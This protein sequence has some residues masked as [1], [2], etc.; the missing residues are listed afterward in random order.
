[1]GGS[2]LSDMTGKLVIETLNHKTD[3]Q[4]HDNM[5][6]NHIGKHGNLDIAD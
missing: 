3:I 2:I 4:G 6:R 5:V 1:M